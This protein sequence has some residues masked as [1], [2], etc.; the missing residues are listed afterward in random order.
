VRGFG[1]DTKKKVTPEASRFI[2]SEREKK[3]HESG[4]FGEGRGGGADW[5]GK[6]LE[7][8]KSPTQPSQNI[9]NEGLQDCI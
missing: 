4:E 9:R 6:R 7:V 1:V 5:K 3:R 8:P 2:L